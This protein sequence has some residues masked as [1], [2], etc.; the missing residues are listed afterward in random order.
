M[1]Q[2][3]QKYIEEDQ[4]SIFFSLGQTQGLTLRTERVWKRYDE[5][6]CIKLSWF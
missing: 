3:D 5:N 2:E 1:T 4:K 6:A